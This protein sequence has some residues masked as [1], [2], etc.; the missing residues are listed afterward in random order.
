M[1][2]FLF[3]DFNSFDD[4]NPWKLTGTSGVV[5]GVILLSGVVSSFK[6]TG[7]VRSHIWRGDSDILG[8][9]DP[10]VLSFGSEIC[11]ALSFSS[12]SSESENPGPIHKDHWVCR[13]TGDFSSGILEA[14]LLP[15]DSQRA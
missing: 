9:K 6:L 8:S 7:Q 11:A 13:T 15:L 3:K 4:V 12:S 1:V 14:S 2:H 10:M 5:D